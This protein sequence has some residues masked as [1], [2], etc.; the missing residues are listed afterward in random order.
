MNRALPTFMCLLGALAGCED[1]G[2]SD[3]R[4]YELITAKKLVE[5]Q[6]AT[7]AILVEVHGLPWRGADPAEVVGTL[8]M[9]EGPARQVRFRPVPPGQ[10]R[11][12]EGARLVLHFNPRGEPNSGRDCRASA[13]IETLD[14]GGDGF[15][16]HATFCRGSGW[17]TRASFDAGDVDQ[18][19]WLAYYLRM[20]VLM[21]VMFPNR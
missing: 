9:P 17:V 19:D 18:D 14:P 12:G 20:M 3:V 15:T 2:I 5:M 1:T 6:G 7:G 16:V 13:E 8:R 21:D 11:I 4:R 10:G